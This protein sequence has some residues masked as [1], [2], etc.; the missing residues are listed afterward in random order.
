LQKSQRGTPTVTT[1]SRRT[2]SEKSLLLRL[3]PR[4]IHAEQ[5]Y[6]YIYGLSLDISSYD[7]DKT[8]F[9]SQARLFE[10]SEEPG[11]GHIQHNQIRALGRGRISHWRNNLYFST[12]DNSSPIDNGREYHLLIPAS[13]FAPD[14]LAIAL[15]DDSLEQMA[16]MVR[17][18]FARSLY[19]K[20]WRDTPLPDH[21][22]RIDH[23]ISFAR[24][25]A[26]LS[27][28]SDVTHERKYN[29]DQLF[30]LVLCLDGDVA[31]CGT[32]KGGSAFFFARHIV[33]DGLNKRLCLFDSFEGLSVPAS[34]DGNYWRAGALASTI[35]DVH[36]TWPR[37]ARFRSW[38]STK[39][40]YPS[41][42]LK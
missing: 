36:V 23:D 21:D 33:E 3:D 6:A 2:S 24:E 4:Q 25:F 40:G 26:R 30:K 18:A 8:P 38:N 27:P 1:A 19:R 22:R 13:G 32:Y 10:N 41:G 29:L 9:R 15:G 37:S 14:D 17:F 34:V 7:S 11:P 16:P 39:A 12:S 31:G 42:S 5:G 20:L 28:E 35:E